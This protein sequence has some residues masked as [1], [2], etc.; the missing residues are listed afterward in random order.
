VALYDEIGR[1][2]RRNRRPDPRIAAA[3]VTALDDADS[4][5]NV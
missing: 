2:Y 5:V 3:V 4:V 1:S